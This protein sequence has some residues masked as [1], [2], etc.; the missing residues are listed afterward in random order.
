MKRVFVAGAYSADNVIDVFDN[1]RIG[2]RAST[3][4]FLEGYA[5]FCP[6]LDWQFLVMLRN[7]ESLTVDDYYAYSLAW[8]EVSDVLY[9]LPDS[10][11]SAGTQNEIKYARKLGIPVVYYIDDIAFALDSKAG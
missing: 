2:T 11:D 1:I 10:E 8:L 6:W 4:I 5:P 9:V 7:G 3:E